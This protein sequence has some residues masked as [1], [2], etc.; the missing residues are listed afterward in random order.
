MAEAQTS[1]QLVAAR[2]DVADA[3]AKLEAH[4]RRIECGELVRWDASHRSIAEFY[5]GVRD[6]FLDVPVRAANVVGEIYNL[7]PARVQL[8]LDRVFRTVFTTIA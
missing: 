1:D 3:I 6:H 7:E 8:A 5:H 4:Q 2:A